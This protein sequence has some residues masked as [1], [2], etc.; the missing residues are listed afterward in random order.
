LASRVP[1]RAAS[2]VWTVVGVEVAGIVADIYKIARGYQLRA[3]I[4]WMILHGI[5]VATAVWALRRERRAY[6]FELRAVTS[7]EI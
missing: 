3:P 6:D 1:A 5:I 4:T 2:L 7:S